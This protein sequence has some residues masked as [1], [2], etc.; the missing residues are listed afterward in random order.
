MVKLKGGAWDG[1]ETPS[2]RWGQEA[3]FGTWDGWPANRTYCWHWYRRVSLTEAVYD[4]TETV[5]V[6]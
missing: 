2:M 4:R 5:E 3:C 1:L 6:G